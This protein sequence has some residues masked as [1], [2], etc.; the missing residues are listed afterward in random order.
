MFET[1]AQM[2][3][4]R[5]VPLYSLFCFGCCFAHTAPSAQKAENVEKGSWL[6][7]L[8]PATNAKGSR[9]PNIREDLW[10]KTA[11]HAPGRQKTGVVARNPTAHTKLCSSSRRRR[12]ARFSA[13]LAAR[14]RLG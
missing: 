4:K 10:K 11:R 1:D 3:H 12:A 7:G 9:E 2:I 14:F 13:P 8:T 5:N 6:T